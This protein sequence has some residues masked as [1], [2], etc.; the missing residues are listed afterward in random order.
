[1]QCIFLRKI[2]LTKIK[3]DQTALYIWNASRPKCVKNSGFDCV[4]CGVERNLAR[5]VTPCNFQMKVRLATDA[6]IT[7]RQK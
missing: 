6:T 7:T 1:M 3:Y 5:T 2:S 4:F